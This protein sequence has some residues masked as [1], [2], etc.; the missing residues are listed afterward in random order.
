MAII[1]SKRRHSFTTIDNSVINDQRL[2][3]DVIGVLVYLLSKPDNW[4]AQPGELR[5][6]FGFGKDKCYKILNSLIETGYAERVES[7]D[8]HGKVTGYDYIVHETSQS[9]FSDPVPEK[10]ETEKPVP[11]NQDHN[12]D[13]LSTSTESNK[14][15]PDGTSA[16]APENVNS[17]IWAEAMALLASAE[18]NAHERKHRTL[19][20]RWCKLASCDP[21]KLLQIVKNAKAAGTRD[22]VP[23]IT[24][25]IG[26]NFEVPA[27]PRSFDRAKWQ[28][29]VKV[30]KSNGKWPEQSWGPRPGGKKKPLVPPDLVDAELLEKLKPVGAML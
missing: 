16:R 15:V 13:G 28:A 1:R 17:T 29:V 21:P 14:A 20:G 10:P 23:Y 22:P 30:A 26:Q 3:C 6:R 12:K 11:E 24:A 19:I 8:E 2:G 9:G 18:P 5:N 27:D 25:A 7:R 4:S